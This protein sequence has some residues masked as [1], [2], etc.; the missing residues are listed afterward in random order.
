M[1]SALHF[2]RFTCAALLA[3]GAAAGTG[4]GNGAD[5]GIA[6]VLVVAAV[7]VAPAALTLVQ[8]QTHTFA[9]TPRTSSGVP[10]TGRAVTWSSSDPGVASI[11]TDGTVSALA[12]GTTRITAR[13]DGVSGSADLTVSTVP[14][15]LVELL[16]KTTTVVS[17]STVQLTANVYDAGGGV[18]TGRQ[19]TWRSSEVLIASVSTDGLVTTHGVGQVTITATVEGK[20]GSA[21]ITVGPRPAAKLGFLT[22]PSDAVAGLALAPAVRVAIQDATGATVSAATSTVTLTLGA[23]PTGATLGGTVSAAAVNGVATFTNLSITKAGTGYTVVA[24]SANLTDATSGPFVIRPAAAARV[25]MTTEPAST[26]ASGTPLSPQPVV[27][28]ADQFGNPVPQAGVVVTASLASGTGT[29][30]SPN[31]TTGATGSAVFTAL[32]ITGVPGIYTLAFGAPGLAGAT[33]IPIALTAGSANRLAFV[34]APPTT[35]TNGQPFGSTVT[36]GLRDAAGNPV[37]QAGV[38]VTVSVASGAGLLSGPPLTATTDAAGVASFTGLIITGIAGPYTLSFSTTGVNPLTSA[39]IQLAP[40]SAT[41]LILAVAPPATAVG[42]APLVPAPAVRLADA[43]G[44]PVSTAGVQVTATLAAGT[45]T[46]AGA[47]ATTDAT[48]LATFSALSISGPAGS[49]ALAFDATGLTGVTTAAI[50]LSAGTP[51][52]VTFTVAPPATAVNGQVLNPQPVVQLRDATGAAVPVAG[53]QVTASAAG[54]ASAGATVTTDAAGVATFSSLSFTGLVG[55]YS[56][57]FTAAGVAGT[58]S[59]PL[60]LAAGPATQLTFTTAPPATAANRQLIAPAPEVQLRDVGGNAV[61]QSGVAV[62]VAIAS[63]PGGVLTGTLTAN[64]SNTGTATFA[65]L[66]IT[67]NT[68]TYTLAFSAAGLSTA[69]SNPMTLVGGPP[70]AIVLST[71]PP[72]STTSGLPL[73]PQP[74]V[75][76][77]DLDGNPSPTSGIVIQAALQAAGGASLTGSVQVITDATG[78]GTYTDL[79]LSGP[80]G[81]YSL[82]FSSA[83]LQG[84]VAGPIQLAAGGPGGITMTTQPSTSAKNDEVFPTQPAV[85]VT[86]VGGIPLSGVQVTVSIASGPAGTLGGTLSATTNASGVAAF[87]NLEI[88]G[89]IGDYTLQF[90]VGTLTVSSN[91]LT[92]LVGAEAHLVITVPPSNVKLLQAIAPS[93]TLELRD[94]GNNLVPVTGQLVTVS[95]ASGN[96]TLLLPPVALTSGGVAVFGGIGGGIVFSDAGPGNGNHTLRFSSGALSVVSGTFKVN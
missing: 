88:V 15:D 89:P 53:V 12:P 47:T 44:N 72:T 43:V 17:G 46:L 23:G 77:V 61:S 29:L 41:K 75:Q 90:A 59:S 38:A 76:L 27:Q 21:T 92:L 84:V 96:G 6:S 13:V 31:A 45:G 16:P 94:S 71:P 83:G 78:R 87:T 34:A 4:C 74:V 82:V 30:T 26:G 9:A 25:D 52:Q 50:T 14:V 28:I 54:L 79:T 3:A 67:G 95:I 22:P 63:G 91:A 65:D 62:S 80:A 70:V 19:L 57:V 85:T 81:S 2:R 35:A 40:G 68:G 39:T 56:L 42:G 64:T 49:Y 32:A 73:S 33:S 8:H 24:K 86:D 93:P 11:A 60:A 18:L 7:D 1:L 55:N 36:V 69:T 58:A 66:V 20:S 37:P 48:G 5:L 10:V 51:T